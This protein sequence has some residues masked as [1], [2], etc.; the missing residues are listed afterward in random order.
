MHWYS[1]HSPYSKVGWHTVYD[2]IFEDIIKLFLLIK[3]CVKMDDD[4]TS[5]TELL[6]LHPN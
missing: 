2:P 4:G 3:H 6:L 5:V 1:F